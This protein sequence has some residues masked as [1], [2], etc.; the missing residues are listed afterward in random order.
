VGKV[1]V[2]SLGERAAELDLHG[3]R[4]GDQRV[5]MEALAQR[6]RRRALTVRV[7]RME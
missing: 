1:K 5:D 7:T 4:L 3:A 6:D 2:P